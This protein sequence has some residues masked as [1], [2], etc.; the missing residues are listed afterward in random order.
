LNPEI[1]ILD[2]ATSSLDTENENK[3]LAEINQIK[4][5]KTIILISHRKNTLASCD[6]IYLLSNKKITLISNDKLTD[7]EQP[8]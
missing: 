6:Y 4:A 3:I 8:K 7:M 2:E 5:N 1:L